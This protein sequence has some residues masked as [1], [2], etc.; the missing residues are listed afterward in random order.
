MA[1]DLSDTRLGID[2]DDADRTGDTDGDDGE[3]EQLVQFVFVGIGEHRLA[4][5][6]DAVRT[7]T[8]PPTELTRVPRSSP[9]IEGLMDLRGE[10]TAVIDPRVHFPATDSR[11]DRERLLVLERASDQQSIAIRVDDVIGVETV[12]ESNVIDADAIADSDLS[13][14]ALEHPLIVALITQERESRA[15]T[16]SAVTDT[17]ADDAGTTT[18]L[19]IDGLDGAGSSTAL[20]SA[21]A[22]S[23]EI[24][25][26]VGEAFEIEPTEDD[27]AASDDGDEDGESTREVVVEATALIDIDRLLQASSQSE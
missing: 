14:D 24:G 21:R 1:P 19:G 20:S 22:A 11:S 12:P 5:P 7:L 4:L 2:S 27:A 16:G 26:S 15:D 10:I 25:E 23:A 18:E 6:V 8:E 13:G 9:A 3:Q 17:P